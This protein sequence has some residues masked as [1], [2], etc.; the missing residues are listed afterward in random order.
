LVLRNG[1]IY[2]VKGYDHPTGY[3]FAYPRY[4][5]SNIGDRNRRGLRYR[6]VASQKDAER[7][8]RTHGLI[9]YDT[10]LNRMLSIVPLDEVAEHL[11]PRSALQ[12][13]IQDPPRSGL[14]RSVAELVRHLSQEAG[15]DTGNVGIIGSLLAE[16]ATRD[17]DIDLA[18]YGEGN[19][20]KVREYVASNLS[21]PVRKHSPA[22]LKAMYLLDKCKE[23][24]DF[25]TFLRH[26][27]LKT[28]H[29]V[30]RSHPV[31]IR[32]LRA[33]ANNDYGKYVSVPLKRV[34]IRATVVDDS[35]SHYTPSRYVLGDAITVPLGIA[36]GRVE[37]LAFRSR[38]SEQAS[39]GDEVVAEGMLE[40]VWK[41]SGVRKMRLVLGAH[42]DDFIWRTR[43]LTKKG[44]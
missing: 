15:V 22:E 43:L 25:G 7:I 33:H 16:T 14:R 40:S 3:A 30:Y 2:D 21:R 44:N 4:F 41:K 6:K 26:E 24:V 5:P 42:N 31:F 36:L 37:V 17:S 1:L 29:A 28:C 9:R 27:Q 34:R 20:S 38:F 19:V 13:I 39:I 18:V 12:R 8:A 35:E 23:S 10:Y 11:K 32:Y